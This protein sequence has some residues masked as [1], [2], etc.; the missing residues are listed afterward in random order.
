VKAPLAVAVLILAPSIALAGPRIDPLPA[1]PAGDES[2]CRFF[3]KAALDGPR[4]VVL[5]WSGQTGLMQI[6]GRPLNMNAGEEQCLKNCVAPGT[7][8]VRVI[9]FAGH[10]AR[11][12]LRIP[13]ACN[14]DAEVCSGLL[15]AEG[16][17]VVSKGKRRT[18]LVVRN[19]DCDQ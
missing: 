14:K 9:H 3:P 12:T 18:R 11:A 4:M 17:L 6:D 7:T 5:E 19:E 2:G 1:R 16:S 15:A 10:G 13:S 8:G